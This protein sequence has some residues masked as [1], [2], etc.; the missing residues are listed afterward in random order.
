MSSGIVNDTYAPVQRVQS[1]A[2]NYQ[3]PRTEQRVLGRFKPLNDRPI[4]NYTP[5]SLAVSYNEGNK[6]VER[7]LGLLNPTGVLTQIAQNTE[8]TNWGARSFKVYNAPINSQTYAGQ[9]NVITGVLK[10]FSLAGSVGGVVEGSF[11]IQAI[12]CQ[13]V[14]NNSVRTVPS[15]SGQVIK[16]ENVSI[17][18]INFTGLGLSGL[19]LQSFNFQINVNHSETFQLG[20]KYPIRRITDGTATLQLAGYMEGTTNTLTTLSGYD[21]GAAL[22]GTYVLALTPNCNSEP[23]TTVTLVNPYAESMSLGARVGTY[24]EINLGFS[25]PLTTVPIEATGVGYGSNVTIT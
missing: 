23:P 14:A 4:L 10:S 13:Q 7:N 5:V 16:S 8:V 19:T 17:T 12:D 21:N 2:L 20:S 24:T 22:N 25:I 15:Y 11:T 6:D 3:L 18:G 9:W 1:I